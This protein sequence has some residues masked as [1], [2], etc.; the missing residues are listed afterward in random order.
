MNDTSRRSVSKGGNSALML[1]G[2][3]VGKGS[4][5]VSVMLLSRYLADA[6]FGGFLFAIV[7]GQVY[8]F[9]SD[10]GV[11]LVLN[12]RASTNPK[13]TQELF[14]TSI[15]LRIILSLAGLPLVMLAGSI[16]DMDSARLAVLGIIGVS[17]FFD[18][19]SEMV[20]SVFRAGEIMV[21]ESV[22][23]IIR[24]ISGLLLVV[25]AIRY[26][27]GLT[28]IAGVYAVRSAAG[29]AAAAW[30]AKR[31]KL[32]LKP[33]WKFDKVKEMLIASLPLGIM[34]LVT[35]LHQRVDNVIVRQLLGENAVAAW[36]ECMK[37]VELMVLLVAPTLLPGA[38]FP[39]LCRAFRNRNF[40]RQTADMA[41]V[42]TAF[43]TALILAV[44]SAGPRFLK[45]LWGSGYLR[46]M[47]S[48]DL[49]LA[50]YLSLAGLAAVYIM[51]ITLASL[52]AINRVKIVVPVTIAALVIVVAGNLL[53]MPVI[54][55][56]SAGLFFF[57][58]NLLIAASY[59]LFL[60]WRGYNLPVW[61]EILISCAAGIPAL[62]AVLLFAG[63]MSL[64]PAVLI[65]LAVYLPVWWFTGGGV[66]FRRLFPL[67]V[68]RD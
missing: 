24:G 45:A 5:F 43:S 57:S 39:S 32:V 19:W 26:Q 48:G 7:L 20:Y 28:A 2:Q 6:E 31:L 51:H 64:V 4:L 11:S 14:S 65:P 55:L 58:G 53:L 36:Q 23:R 52:L 10:M 13:D 60:R 38:L 56:P 21:Y 59:W 9:M 29:L 44:A 1:A 68:T 67:K 33:C 40:T 27:A 22:S 17:V 63:N 30:G 62:A 37:V 8:L 15:S 25:L 3:F 54:G 18:S 16:L 47:D 12:R 50:F 66:A 41:R 42:F 61:R 34:G 35:I 46:Q 49:Q